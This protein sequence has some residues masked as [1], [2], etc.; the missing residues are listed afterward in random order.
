MSIRLD[1]GLGSEEVTKMLKDWAAYGIVSQQAQMQEDQ[2]KQSEAQV[3]E[4]PI[5][6]ADQ[7]GEDIAERGIRVSSRISKK[8]A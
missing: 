5:S 6:R 8:P 2:E 1:I 7:M 3:E 4:M